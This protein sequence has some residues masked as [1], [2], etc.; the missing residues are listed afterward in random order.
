MALVTNEK[1]PYEEVD[2]VFDFSNR[3]ISDGVTITGVHSIT[4]SRVSGTGAVTYS[5]TVYSGQYVQ[6]RFAG[7]NTG[8]R[9]KLTA[10]VVMSDGQRY[11]CDGYLK[12]KEL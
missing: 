9:Y 7:G 11:E 12:I 3:G 2:L 6:S 10:K 4:V 1:Q 8:D 5:G